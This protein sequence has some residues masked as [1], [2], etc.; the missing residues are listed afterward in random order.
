MKHKGAINTKYLA[1]IEYQRRNRKKHSF[2]KELRNC[3]TRI[4]RL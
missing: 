1:L 4:I 3:I 2:L